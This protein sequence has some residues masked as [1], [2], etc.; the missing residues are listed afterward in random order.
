MAN[1]II[2]DIFFNEGAYGEDFPASEN[3]KTILKKLEEMENKIKKYLPKN[4]KD[5]IIWDYS[6]LQGE[7]NSEVEISSFT[8]GFKTGL[9]LGAEVFSD[10]NKND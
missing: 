4:K 1:S 6:Y 10:I 2:K 9:L 3:S 7:L 5:K 8:A